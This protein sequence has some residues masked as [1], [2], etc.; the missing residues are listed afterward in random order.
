MTADNSGIRRRMSVATH[1]INLDFHRFAAG[2]K[3][4]LREKTLRLTPERTLF[5]HSLHD[6]LP[7][8]DRHHAT[9]GGSRSSTNHWSAHP[10]SNVVLSGN[11]N[12]IHQK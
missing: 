10:D 7:R 11:D 9:Y 8:G 12:D 2:T 5:M 3:S 6:I 1:H 4:A